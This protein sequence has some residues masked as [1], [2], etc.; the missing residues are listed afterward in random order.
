MKY[1]TFFLKSSK[2]SVHFTLIAHCNLD[3]TFSLEIISIA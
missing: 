3:A 2:S 1:F